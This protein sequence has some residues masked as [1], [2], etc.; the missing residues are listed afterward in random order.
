MQVR[1]AV[2]FASTEGAEELS[3]VH[4]GI[5]SATTDADGSLDALRVEGNR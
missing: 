5:L 2:G 3:W 1:E 4:G